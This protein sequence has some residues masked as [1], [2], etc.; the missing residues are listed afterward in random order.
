M[1]ATCIL[2]DLKSSSKKSGRT[3]NK[4]TVC[5]S[6]FKYREKTIRVKGCRTYTHKS[7]IFNLNAQKVGE[8]EL[9][10]LRCVKSIIDHA[11]VVM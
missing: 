6:E 4:Q 8:P 11:L 7:D 1:I 2:G 3:A 5:G 9:A 10:T